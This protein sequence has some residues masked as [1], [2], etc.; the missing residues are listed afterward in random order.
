MKKAAKRAE[1]MLPEYDFR[2]GSLGKYAARFAAGSNVAIL[3]PDVAA[4]FPDSKSVNEAL[5]ALVK[6]AGG[7]ASSASRRGRSSGGK[8]S[9]KAR[10]F[11]ETKKVRFRRGA[12]GS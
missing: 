2:R 1:D 8:A 3:D 5:R 9:R 4:S 12:R 7:R 6:I 10:A 11:D